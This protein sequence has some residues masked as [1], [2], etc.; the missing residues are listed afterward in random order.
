M[1][2]FEYHRYDR[3][4]RAAS[5]T[6]HGSKVFKKTGGAIINFPFQQL[7]NGRAKNRRTAHKYKEYARALKNGENALV[8]A[9]IMEAKPSYFMECLA[10]NV[11]DGDLTRGG[12]SRSAWFRH[13]LATLHNALLPSRFD[14]EDWVEPNELKYL[15]H[16]TQKWKVEDA[17]DLTT[18]LWDYLEYE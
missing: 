9:R 8:K 1:P 11:P 16:A 15:F 18:N 6:Q 12:Y 5:D 2:A 7:E 3:P 10:Y 17:R 14:N 4:D 13:A